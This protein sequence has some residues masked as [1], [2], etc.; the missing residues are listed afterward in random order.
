MPSTFQ[1]IW[2]VFGLVVGLAGTIYM[3]R[4]FLTVPTHVE[5]LLGPAE[6]AP[7]PDAKRAIRRA[8]WMVRA[9]AMTVVVVAMIVSDHLRSR[10]PTA[11]VLVAACAVSIGWSIVGTRI[12]WRKSMRHGVDPAMLDELAEDA[13]LVW[14]RESYWGRRQRR[15]WMHAG[16]EHTALAAS[17]TGFEP[18]G[19]P[20]QNSR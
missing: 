16:A 1:L 19:G 17:R 3:L 4:R 15:A 12:W 6:H 13:H 5:E 2:M 14:R 20:S 8:I 18:D 7:L 11:A 9:P 10:W